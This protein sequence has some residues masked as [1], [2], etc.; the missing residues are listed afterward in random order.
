MSFGAARTALLALAV[1]LAATTALPS[2]TEASRPNLLILTIDTLRADRLSSYGYER[3]T[4][5][6]LDRLIAS[7]IRFTQARTVEPLTGPALCSMMTSR[8]PHEH[9]ATRNGLRMRTGLDSLPKLLNSHGYRTAAILANWTLKDRASNLGEHF[10]DYR[11]VLKRKRW[12]GLV[13][14]EATADDVTE[15]AVEW[16]QDYSDSGEDRPFF[17]W[18]H[19][20]E[21]HAPYRLQKDRLEALGLPLK[22]DHPP[23]DRYDTE[24]AEVDRSIGEL[25]ARVQALGL[26]R[27]LLTVFTSDHGESLGEH[28]YWGHGRH[29]YEPTLHVP[30]SLTWPGRLEPATITAPALIIDLAPTI[31]GLVGLEP[32]SSF[33]GYDWTPTVR[34]GDQPPA[35]RLTHHQAHKGAVISDHDSDLARRSGLL[36]VAVIQQGLKEIFRVKNGRHWKFDLATDPRELVNLIELKSSPSERLQGM[37]EVVSSGLSSLDAEVPEPLDEES[38][39]RLRALGYAD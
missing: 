9:G 18:V 12:F 22:G 3:P 10:E 13:S 31:A 1:L 2:G 24:I 28:N 39:E 7:G 27:E 20:V 5:P 11:M 32:P 36:E 23:S 19:Y 6:N 26:G 29:L 25:L 14:S 8:Y 17:L 21:P 16:L 37:I 4:S 35:G 33:V 15:E 30:M 38:I 34:D